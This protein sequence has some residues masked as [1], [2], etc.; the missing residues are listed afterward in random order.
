ME[1]S[2]VVKL[3]HIKEKMIDFFT[4][5]N[6][7]RPMLTGKFLLQYTFNAKQLIEKKH[8]YLKNY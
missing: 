1:I 5:Q 6:R 2:K 3:D 4:S 7:L 8:F